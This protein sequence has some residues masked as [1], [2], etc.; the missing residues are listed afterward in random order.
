MWTVC[1]LLQR[2]GYCTLGEAFNRL[3][4][5][6][7]IQ[8]VR[9]FNYVVK[10]RTFRPSLNNCKN[11]S[12]RLIY[13]L[14]FPSVSSLTLSTLFTSL[15]FC[16]WLPNPS[17][18]LWVELLR[19]T[20]SMSWR[21]LWEKVSRS[22]FLTLT[23]CIEN[24]EDILSWYMCIY[25]YTCIFVC[26]FNCAVLDDHQTPRLVKTLLNDLSSTLCILIRE[27]G[28]SVLIGN[29]NIWV[30]RLET[31]LNWQQQLNNL[32]IPKVVFA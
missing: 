18:R 24:V 7:A 5:S 10:V 12:L 3:D 20:I 32:Q 17:W 13:L 30:C 23:S 16:S 19:K 4:F 6:S 8:D 28:K 15:S 29:I 25:K 9:R 2:H 1:L 14:C 21:R 31:I 27:V 11:A 26:F 22:F